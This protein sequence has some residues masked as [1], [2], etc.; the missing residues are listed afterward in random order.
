MYFCQIEGNPSYFHQIE[1]ILSCISVRLRVS[2]HVF[3]TDWGYSLMYFW[4]IEGILSCIS[5]RLRVSS[6]VFL[7]DWGYPLMYFCQIE[8]IPSCISVRLRVSSYVFLSDWGYP[9]ML[10]LVKPVGDLLKVTL[11]HASSCHVNTN[12]TVDHKNN[13]ITHNVYKQ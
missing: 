11:H 5:V 6:H 12:C 13:T 9:L 4:Q 1:G 7:S 2:S 3:L 10:K 8:G